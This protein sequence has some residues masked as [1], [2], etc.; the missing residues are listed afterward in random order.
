MCRTPPLMATVRMPV[1]ARAAVAARTKAVRDAGVEA[2][3]DARLA[4]SVAHV[5]DEFAPERTM[6]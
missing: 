2:G 6:R 5:G 1:A 3:R 4:D